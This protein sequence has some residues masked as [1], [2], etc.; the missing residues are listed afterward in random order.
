MAFSLAILARSA[1]AASLEITADRATVGTIT[2]RAL[3]LSLQP[4]GR[5]RVQLGEI[6]VGASILVNSLE[7]NCARL[8]LQAGRATCESG[9]LLT[10]L[11]SGPLSG[12]WSLSAEQ[13]RRLELKLQLKQAAT[14][15]R[16]A[17]QL[18]G[19]RLSADLDLHLADAA[20]LSA[21]AAVARPG[22]LPTALVMQGPLNLG[23]QLQLDAQRQSLNLQLSSSALTASEASG[24]LASDRLAFGAELEASREPPRSGHAQPLIAAALKLSLIGGQAY[25]EP[26]FEDF[27]NAALLAQG[28]LKLDPSRAEITVEKMTLEQSDVM[29]AQASGL[30]RLKPFGVET[31]DA[32]LTRAELPGFYDRYLAPWLA[33]K[34]GEDLKTKG[35]VSAQLRL[36]LGK[37]EQLQLQLHDVQL[38][39]ER[40]NL[41]AAGLSGMLAWTAAGQAPQATQLRWA[42]AR[43]AKLPL[44]GA[45]L[46]AVAQGDTL[47]LTAALRQ[48]V[49]DGA[50]RI[51]RLE[52]GG[53]GSDNPTAQLQAEVEPIDLAKLST[54]LGWPTF[55]GQL[56]G[57]LPALR[58][59]NHALA[60]DGA[61]TADVFDGNLR[62]ENLRWS[63]PLGRSQKLSAD[64]RLRRFDLAQLTGAFSFGRIDGRMDGDITGLR[65]LGFK[66]VAFDAR[67]YTSPTKPG[68][69]RISQRA[70]DNISSLGGGPTGVVSKGV[71][72]FFKDFAYDRIGWSCLLAN[73]VCRMD[74]VEPAKDGGYVLV[75]GALLPRIDV[76]GHTRRVDWDT[77]YAQLTNLQNLQA[78]TTDSHV[79]GGK[80]P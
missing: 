18:D 63:E 4:Q 33:G 77:F 36:R 72:R 17:L 30:A 32:T 57:K 48:P 49:L 19:P 70:I 71:L 25:A 65:L 3:R 59:R 68:R 31:L 52:L 53:I 79:G 61:L 60:L 13:Q 16:M 14:S 10:Q 78:P 11:P 23:A 64:V 74:G 76:I 12:Q 37:P 55:A 47:R 7:L 75:K 27:S 15:S 58:L 20:L 34:P 50:L 35:T 51:D 8:L 22:L 66:P 38:D 2:A 69:R 73:G 42:S 9:R 24:R 5:A 67:L 39:S 45:Q 80:P 29:S 44:A 54:A 62:I 28:R 56:A 26:I 1:G 40:Q 21:I 46:D 6:R 43:F 41:A